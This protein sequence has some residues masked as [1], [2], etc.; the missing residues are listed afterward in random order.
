MTESVD[1]LKIIPPGVTKEARL[2]LSSLNL[3]YDTGFTIVY[4]LIWE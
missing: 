3:H 1:M 2:V 4:S